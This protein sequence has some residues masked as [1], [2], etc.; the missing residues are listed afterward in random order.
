MAF[1]LSRLTQ[2]LLNRSRGARKTTATRTTLVTGSVALGAL[3]TGAVL[4]KTRRN[5]LPKADALPKALDAEVREFEIIEG[6][7]RYYQRAGTG[8]P[9]VLLHSVNAAASSFEIKPIFDHLKAHT[10]RPL[11]ALDLLG[12]GLSDRPAVRY[13]PG[14]YQRE[15]R[16]FLSERVRAAADVIALSLSC[17]YA[18]TVANAFPVLI[19]R[20]VFISPAGLSSDLQES[21]L[22]RT[23]VGAAST[24]GAFDLFFARLTQRSALRDFYA[25]HVFLKPE[26]VP[27]ALVDYAYLTS[28]VKGAH[29]AP[30]RFIQGGLSMRAYAPKVYAAIKKPTLFVIPEANSDMV[31]HF[32][33]APEI[34]AE[35]HEYIELRHIDAGLLP[36]W[37]KPVALF[38]A[39]DPFIGA[40]S[41]VPEQAA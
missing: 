32:A 21:I 18:A 6:R 22:Q 25:E 29:N 20:M 19:N 13:S 34:A 2:N 17:E 7:V 23:V 16:R 9:I 30:R 35:N 26:N 38:E 14:L 27:S 10:D 41:A 40:E 12:F 8:V 28:H 31:Q 37:E 3:V 24:V 39:I 4:E 33:R 11:Y 5:R 36:Q 15:L 1:S